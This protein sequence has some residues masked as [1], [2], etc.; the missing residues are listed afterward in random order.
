MIFLC[1]AMLSDDT[2]QASFLKFYSEYETMLYQVALSVLHDPAFAEDAVQESWLRIAMSFHRIMELKKHSIKGYLSILVKN[3]C[4]DMNR[5]KAVQEELLE[6]WKPPDLSMC[7]DILDMVTMLIRGMPVQYREI[8]ERKYI[9]GYSN[10]EIARS[11]ELNESTV[12]S[13][14]MCGRILLADIL[15]KEGLNESGLDI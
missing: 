5:K 15:R 12:A 3:V 10:R 13:R 6:N 7:V 9:L 14:A 4:V 2:E 8:L 11:L 1:L